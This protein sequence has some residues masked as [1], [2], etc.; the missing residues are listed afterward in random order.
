VLGGLIGGGRRGR[1]RAAILGLVV[2]ALAVVALV[3]FIDV[4]ETVDAL[5][6]AD[7]GWL[8]LT[9]LMVPAQIVLRSLRWQLLLPR[10][11]DGRRPRLGPIMASLLVGQFANLVLPARLG[12]AVR[13]YLVGRR[14][15]IAFPRVLGSVLLERVIDVATLALVAIGA[16]VLAGAPDWIVRGSEIVAIVGGVVVVLLAASAIP[17]GVRLMGRVVGRIGGMPRLMAVATAFG[18]GAEGDSR[19]SLIGA[20]VVSTATWFFVGA[21]FWMVGRSLDMSIDPAAAMLIAAVTSLGMAIPSAPANIGT[22]EAAAV[23]AATA[24]GIGAPEALALGI[25]A[26]VVSTVPFAVIGGIAV[27]WMSL[28]LRSVASD[29]A[30]TLG[31]SL[32]EPDRRA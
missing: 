17:R 32:P 8:A 5:G 2:S 30:A 27:A 4:D 7:L 12:E 20:V 28:S 16:A 18:E 13:A 23:V 6:T 22:W 3:T 11:A 1:T 10:D 29:A 21:T 25:A 19:R 9:I 14:E 31:A 24:L 26:H 15:Q